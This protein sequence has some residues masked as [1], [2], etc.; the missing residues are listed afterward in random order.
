MARRNQNGAGVKGKSKIVVFP[1]G[2]AGATFCRFDREKGKKGIVQGVFLTLRKLAR[3]GAS[4]SERKDY[5][6]GGNAEREKQDTT[7]DLR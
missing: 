5:S 2:E 1:R 7:K 6:C 4:F 3:L